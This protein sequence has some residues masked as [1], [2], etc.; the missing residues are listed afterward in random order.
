M[1]VS[2]MFAAKLTFKIFFT[3]RVLIITHK[4]RFNLNFFIIKTTSLDSC[5]TWEPFSKN[6]LHFQNFLRASF[7][8]YCKILKFSCNQNLRIF[9]NYSLRLFTEM[10]LKN[11]RI[12][13][14]Q[15]LHFKVVM[16]YIK[17]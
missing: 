3:V 7:V 14:K 4:L 2:F 15:I 11:L 5:C 12:K 1:H 13:P 10:L 9:V 17:I 16:Q 6:F 8:N